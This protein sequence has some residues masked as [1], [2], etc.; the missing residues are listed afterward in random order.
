MR[1]SS[2][3]SF[4]PTSAVSWGAVETR[5]ARLFFVLEH[6]THEDF[7]LPVRFPDTVTVR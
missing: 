7:T 6:V 2:D 3:P 5:A 4:V 1:V